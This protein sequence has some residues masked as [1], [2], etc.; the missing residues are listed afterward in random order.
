MSRQFSQGEFVYLPSSTLIY[1]FGAET[2]DWFVSQKTIDKPMYLMFL[3]DNPHNSSYCDIFFE[4]SVWSAKLED[5][6]K[7]NYEGDDNE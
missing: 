6:Y 1:K 4:G 5:I 7:Y 2:C 3:K